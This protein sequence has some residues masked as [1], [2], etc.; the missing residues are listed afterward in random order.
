ME[1][2]SLADAFATFYDDNVVAVYSYARARVGAD[3]AEDVVAEV[4]HAAALAW[5]QGRADQISTAWLIGVARNKI[6]DRWRKA[7]RRKA[8]AHLLG[9][10]GDQTVFPDDWFDDERRE[11]VLA[12]MDRLSDRH[13][14][15]L[16]LHYLDG[17]RV[18]EI[19][20]DLASSERA[21][22]SALARARRAFRSA[23]QE[24]WM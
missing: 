20:E 18:R 4:F 17:M 6:I 19:A 9:R 5:R 10:P 1:A 22:E 11:A 3:D 15:L 23:Y 2:R 12:A 13:R 14:S 21:V 7:Q 8:K 24:Q 16:I